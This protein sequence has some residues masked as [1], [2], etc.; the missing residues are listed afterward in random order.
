[1]PGTSPPPPISNETTSKRSR[2]AS[3]HVRDARAV[4]HVGI[5]YLRWRGKR[6]R[7]SRRMRTRSFAYLARGPWVL[8]GY[9]LLDSQL[10]AVANFY[11]CKTHLKKN[12]MIMTTRSIS[13]IF[14]RKWHLMFICTELE[15]WAHF[16]IMTGINAKTFTCHWSNYLLISGWETKIFWYSPK[17]GSLLYSLYKIPL[18][19]A[20]FPLAR[21]NFH[22][23][24]RAGER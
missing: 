7:H 3:R 1:M 6:S 11:H 10:G 20:C 9:W 16:V 2:H 17:L 5:T 15:F 21:P 12:K 23:H 24:W 14:H 4:M 22:S 8:H 13:I 19:Q 18:A